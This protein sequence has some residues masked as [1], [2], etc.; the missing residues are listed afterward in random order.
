MKLTEEFQRPRN[1]K[2]KRPLCVSNVRGRIPLKS[3]N[4][5]TLHRKPK[6]YDAQFFFISNFCCIP[7]L[8]IDLK[9]EFELLIIQ[10]IRP[11]PGETCSGAYEIWRQLNGLQHLIK[12]LESLEI[13][14]FVKDSQKTLREEIDKLVTAFS[15]DDTEQLKSNIAIYFKPVSVFPLLILNI[16][17]GKFELDEELYDEQVIYKRSPMDFIDHLWELLSRKIPFF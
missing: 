16:F 6:W 9:C 13:V 2:Q 8:K 3:W 11:L 1:Q 7:N 15:K 17:L 10:I 12:G 14:W 4:S 5:L